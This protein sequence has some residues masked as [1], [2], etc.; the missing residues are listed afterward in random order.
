[1]GTNVACKVSVFEVF[2]VRISPYLVRINA[3]RYGVSLRIQSKCGKMR[4]RK[5]PNTDTLTQ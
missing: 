3:D 5:N 2:L 4:T 1:M